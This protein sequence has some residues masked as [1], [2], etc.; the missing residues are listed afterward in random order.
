MT[1]KTAFVRRVNN[2]VA[3]LEADQ[4]KSPATFCFFERTGGL[5]SA[6]YDSLN[7]GGLTEDALDLVAANRRLALASA[8]LPERYVGLRQEHGDK[9]LILTQE[10][11]DNPIQYEALRIAANKGADAIVCTAEGISCLIV[12]ADCAPVV[13]CAKAGFS[14]AHCG[15]KGTLAKTAAKT[16]APL[17]ELTKEDS[18]TFFA[19]IGPCIGPE[20][21]AVSPE[22]AAVFKN[23]YGASI[24]PTQNHVDLVAAITKDLEA[25][26]IPHDHIYSAGI[27]TASHTDRFFSYRKE[28]P[29][30]GR[31]ATFA[32]LMPQESRS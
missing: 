22:L 12:T 20:D 23:A 26:G 13:I 21:F 18:A 8:N 9:H 5:S 7:V 2:D 16:V 3:W 4:Q 27:S 31:Q 11:A 17:A 32:V 14:V 25:T 19:Y 1:A 6:P 28:G 30:T 10:V 29:N 24:C 15:W